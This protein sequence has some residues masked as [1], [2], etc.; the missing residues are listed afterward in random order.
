MVIKKQVITD[1]TFPII[2]VSTNSGLTF[3]ADNAALAA[4]VCKSVALVLV[5]FPPY[6]PKGVLL[7]PTM[8]TPRARKIA[9]L[10]TFVSN[11]YGLINGKVFHLPLTTLDIVI[12]KF[13]QTAK[14]YK[15]ILNVTPPISKVH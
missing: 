2:T 15:A 9:W 10:L 3:A 7:A 14:N 1:K 13:L 6:V 8:N 11:L 5:N 4:K 12:M